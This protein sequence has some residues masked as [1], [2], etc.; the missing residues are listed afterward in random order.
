VPDLPTVAETLPGYQ[1]ASSYGIGAPRNTSV[2][3]VEVLNKAV[4]AGLADPKLKARLTDLGSVPLPGPPTTF[5]KLTADETDKWGK[6]IRFAGVKPG[7]ETKLT[8]CQHW[9]L[10]VEALAARAEGTAFPQRWT[11]AALE[12]PAHRAPG[13]PSRVTTTLCRK[14]AAAPRAA[15]AQSSD[16]RERHNRSLHRKADLRRLDVLPELPIAVPVDIDRARNLQGA[17]LEAEAIA[18]PPAH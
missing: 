3:V 4:N 17:P 7:R 12:T 9:L 15:T 13:R 1:A 8:G 2:E 18:V 5:G 14:I 6:V 11:G 16:H 10:V